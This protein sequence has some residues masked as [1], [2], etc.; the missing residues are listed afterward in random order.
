VAGIEY[1]ADVMMKACARDAPR[2]AC[3]LVF[4]DGFTVE[5]DNIRSSPG[6]FVMNEGQ[7]I[8][9]VQQYGMFSA[10]WH[11]HPNG[12]VNPSPFDIEFHLRHYDDVCMIIA[13]AE[14]TGVYAC[15]D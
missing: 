3:G 12:D 10:I 1:D 4:P 2:E 9:A 15:E 6:Q 7:F 11:T 13:T 5:I 14:E 8:L